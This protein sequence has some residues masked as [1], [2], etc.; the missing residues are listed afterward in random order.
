MFWGTTTSPVR[1]PPSIMRLGAM[2][3]QTSRWQELA[4]EFRTIEKVGYDIA[5]VAD[6]LTHATLPGRWL[7]D[8]FATLAAAAGVTRTL[9]LGTLVAS[10]VYRTPVTLARAAATVADIS[11]GRLVVGLGAGSPACAAA[12]R[13]AHPSKRD[14]VDRFSQLVEGLREVWAGATEWHGDALAFEGLETLPFAPGAA[15]P[16]LLLA[17]HGPR[18]L[19]LVARF[20]DGWSTYGGLG[21]AELSPE[22]FWTRIDEQSAAFV[23]ACEHRDRDPSAVRR[24][25]LLGF[26]SFRPTESV[27]SFHDAVERADRA[28]FDEVVFYWPD[29]EPGDRFWSDTEVHAEALAQLA[30][31]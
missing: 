27:A 31:N 20:G 29:G 7:G 21:V 9:E 12:D 6:H 25:L 8:G 1:V 4:R 16:H 3:L 18:G 17:A 11:G 28:G 5:Y 24:S 15:A 30:K 26:G 23:A 14:M 22:E 19:D 13:A 10:A 2:V